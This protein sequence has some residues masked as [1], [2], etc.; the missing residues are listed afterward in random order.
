MGQKGVV[1][2]VIDRQEASLTDPQFAKERDSILEQL[3]QQKQNQALQLFM[4]NLE[5]RMEKEGKVKI[6]KNEMNN[7]SK[8]RG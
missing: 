4:S 7:L 8:N 5:S 6:N 1:L 2:Q 3:N